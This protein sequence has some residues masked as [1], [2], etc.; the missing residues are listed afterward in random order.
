MNNIYIYDA[1]LNKCSYYKK[2]FV[3][4]SMTVCLNIK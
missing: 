4:D 1:V 3:K 2:A